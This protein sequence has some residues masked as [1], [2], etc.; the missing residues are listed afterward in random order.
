M[1][2]KP[3]CESCTDYIDRARN[4]ITQMCSGFRPEHL[5]LGTSLELGKFL[6]RGFGP[7]SPH[8]IESGAWMLAHYL[9][10]K[11]NGYVELHGLTSS[12]NEEW[13]YMIWSVEDGNIIPLGTAQ[14]EKLRLGELSVSDRVKQLANKNSARPVDALHIIL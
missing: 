13:I 9:D 8:G 1:N 2:G 5:T 4:V 6:P 11:A 14:A 10:Q 12:G 3:Y 7:C